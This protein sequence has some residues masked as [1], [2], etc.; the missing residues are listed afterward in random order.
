M[1]WQLLRTTLSLNFPISPDFLCDSNYCTLSPKKQMFRTLNVLCKVIL[2]LTTEDVVAT[3][4]QLAN[5][6]PLVEGPNSYSHFYGCHIYNS[7]NLLPFLTYT[8]LNITQHHH[9][10]DIASFSQRKPWPQVF[11]SED[12]S[13]ANGALIPHKRHQLLRIQRPETQKCAHNAPRLVTTDADSAQS[14]LTQQI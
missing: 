11:G 1:R 2:H 8:P 12:C 3:A 4:K 9:N 6:V 13:V 14:R 7:I 10:A 5:Y